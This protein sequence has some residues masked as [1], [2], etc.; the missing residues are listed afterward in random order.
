MQQMRPICVIGN[1]NI[2]VVLG[3]LADWPEPGTECFVPRADFRIGGS[4]G[5]TALILARLGARGGLVSAAGQDRLGRMI[6]DR[7][8]G[9]LD[10]IVPVDGQTGVSV[11]VL[12]PGAER[13]FLSFNGHLDAIDLPMIMRALSGWP[14]QGA[15]A[16]VSGAF[17]MPG[18]LA[19][20]KALL[21]HLSAA[22]AEVAID[23]GWP[24]GGWT[25][26]AR[27]RLQGWMTRADQLLLNDKELCGL[28][29]SDDIDSALRMLGRI[30]P[31]IQVVVK[32][33]RDGARLG[34]HHAAA[35]AVSVFDTVGAG[36]AF[37]AGYLDALARGAG[38][39]AALARGVAVASET[40]AR[41]P[42]GE[43][44]EGPDAK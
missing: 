5:N 6:T 18:L 25:V 38:P 1:V 12:H 28:T 10:R 41:F 27:A 43:A 4:A 20:Q 17:A 15:L 3:P 21:D 33:G 26:D 24:G 42:R 23:P 14:L 19:G 22:G 40:V 37:N 35:P 31:G 39:A 8:C 9:P 2:D 44:E 29:G 13:S 7:F 16:L 36:D 30:A 32:A 34:P 11:G